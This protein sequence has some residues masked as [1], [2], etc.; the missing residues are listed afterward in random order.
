MFHITDKFPIAT[1]EQNKKDL[2][3]DQKKTYGHDTIDHK[4]HK[5]L[6]QRLQ[7][8]G[9]KGTVLEWFKSYL[10]NSSRPLYL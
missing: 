6:L 7:H 3:I 9:I 1:A 10:K 8:I 4:I 5:I 2:I